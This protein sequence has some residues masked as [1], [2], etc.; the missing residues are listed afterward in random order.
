ML[1]TYKIFLNNNTACIKLLNWI[2]NDYDNENQSVEY[3]HFNDIIN[4]HYPNGFGLKELITYFSNRG[5]SIGFC[6]VNLKGDWRA[7]GV[8]YTNVIICNDLN[9]GQEAYEK[10]IEYGFEL[11]ELT[12][13]QL[14]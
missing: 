12:E 8:S 11:F 4:K 13:Q 2:L 3:S 1:V 10:S 9:S 14:I 6:P 5:V 7:I